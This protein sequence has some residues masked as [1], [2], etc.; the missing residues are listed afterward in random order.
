MWLISSNKISNFN[1]ILIQFQ[2]NLLEL[3]EPW[4]RGGKLERKM[5]FVAFGGLLVTAPLAQ[6]VAATL[7][8]LG[9]CSAQ[10]TVASD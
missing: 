1:F 7:P 5:A 6:G 10:L 2:V 9:S 8:M 4:R 3:L